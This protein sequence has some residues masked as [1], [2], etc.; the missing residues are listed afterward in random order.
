M[1]FVGAMARQL[2]GPRRAL[3]NAIAGPR[4]TKDALRSAG[5]RDDEIVPFVAA[6]VRYARE[7]AAPTVVSRAVDA[8]PGMARLSWWPAER[9][10]GS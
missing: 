1:D 5:L 6:L 8:V 7:H 3:S 9:S 4:T 2:R 10:T